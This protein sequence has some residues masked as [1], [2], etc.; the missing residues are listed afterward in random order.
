MLFTQFLVEVEDKVPPQEPEKPEV[1]SAAPKPRLQ[2]RQ[3]R[4]PRNEPF[5]GQNDGYGTHDSYKGLWGAELM[6]KVADDYQKDTGKEIDHSIKSAF[7]NSDK[8]QRDF[9]SE[10]KFIK[11]YRNNLWR[12]Y[13]RGEM[14]GDVGSTQD[15]LR[16]GQHFHRRDP[17]FDHRPTL[18]H[19]L[20]S[21]F[22]P[23]PYQD[24]VDYEDDDDREFVGQ[25][26]RKYW[27]G[28]RAHDDELDR[29]HP[30]AWGRLKRGDILYDTGF[31]SISAGEG[32]PNDFAHGGIVMEIIGPETTFNFDEYPENDGHGMIYK[33]YNPDQSERVIMPNVPLT[34]VGRKGKG[35]SGEYIFTMPG[36]EMESYDSY[37]D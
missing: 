31:Q 35:T 30:F 16:R 2:L 11:H 10:D 5:P 14:D 24:V 33:P 26:G 7:R 9:D 6:H 18:W 29:R 19:M 21:T 13:V 4:P 25:G 8:H 22:D 36:F 1:V 23:S 34:Y 32:I 17:N 20:Q 28:V 12:E 15:M 37:Q 27:R 3:P